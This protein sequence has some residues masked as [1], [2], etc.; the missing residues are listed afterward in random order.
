MRRV[1]EQPATLR[2]LSPCAVLQIQSIQ[3]GLGCLYENPSRPPF[4]KGGERNSPY[5]KG[6]TG[7][8]ITRCTHPALS[9]TKEVVI[10]EN[11]HEGKRR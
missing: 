8:L 2:C 3:E 5:E 1:K 6:G 10:R 11:F 4:N 7:D 9:V